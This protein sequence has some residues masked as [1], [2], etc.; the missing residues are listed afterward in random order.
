[1]FISGARRGWNREGDRSDCIVMPHR[2]DAAYC[3]GR[4]VLSVCLLFTAANPTKTDETIEMPFGI[5]TRVG[6][7]NRVSGGDSDPPR[8]KGNFEVISYREYH[9]SCIPAWSEVIR[10][11]AA[12][13]RPPAVHVVATCR[14]WA[15]ALSELT[16]GGLNCACPFSSSSSPDSRPAASSLYRNT[17]H[18]RLPVTW[19][20]S[21]GET[22]RQSVNRRTSGRSGNGQST[23]D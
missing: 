1:M 23:P 16:S 22:N 13:M 5:R 2:I 12:A 9:I 20:F 6:R 3:Y 8:G 15:T 18:P 19:P 11:V 4:S 7:R 17:A 10:Q 14:R 21:R